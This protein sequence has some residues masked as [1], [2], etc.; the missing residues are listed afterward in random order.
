M[1]EEAPTPDPTG[2]PFPT[3]PPV[4]ADAPV[5]EPEDDDDETGESA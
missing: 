2:C 3:N 4:N 5:P 1:A